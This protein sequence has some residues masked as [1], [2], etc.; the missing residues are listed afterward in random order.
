MGCGGIGVLN[1]KVG[2]IEVNWDFFDKL[3]CIT[4]RSLVLG[5]DFRIGNIR[6]LE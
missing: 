1:I 3:E 6:C 2:I 4:C 5:K